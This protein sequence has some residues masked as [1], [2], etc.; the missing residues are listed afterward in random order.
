MYLSLPQTKP[1]QTSQPT[2]LQ[3]LSPNYKHAKTIPSPT[4]YYLNL[5]PKRRSKTHTYTYTQAGHTDSP[6]QTRRSKTSAAK[7]TSGTVSF[8]LARS[9]RKQRSASQHP[10][11]QS[12]TARK[13]T[14]K[15][16]DIVDV[17][18][19][20][21]D[22]QRHGRGRGCGCGG[23]C[24]E[25]NRFARVRRACDCACALANTVWHTEK[26]GSRGLG[27][28]WWRGELE[29]SEWRRERKCFD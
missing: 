13:T 4:H 7:R 25:V 10:C 1:D 28:R 6:Q 17:E 5:N 15:R 8:R 18:A 29:T 26:A 27:V 23:A 9:L 24:G 2:I 12:P 3:T 16:R 11:S 20:S 22:C 14:C 19:F 21:L